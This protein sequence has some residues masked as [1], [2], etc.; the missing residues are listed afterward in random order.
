[1]RIPAQQ[2]DLLAYS[3]L[4]RA[5]DNEGNLNPTKLSTAIKKLGANQFKKLVPDPVMRKELLDY[6]KLSRM[7]QEAQN[8]MF[9][10]NTGQRNR[11]AII[12]AI[13]SILGHGMS[14]NI[15]T[16]AAPLA[17]ILTGKMATKALTSEGLRESLVKEMIKN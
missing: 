7:N 11:D 16:L 15:G 6:S 12:T 1:E 9:N 13:L 8:L 4:S 17:A 2:R 10:P 3:Y 14:G 5:L